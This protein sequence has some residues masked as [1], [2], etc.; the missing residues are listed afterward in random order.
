[1]YVIRPVRVEDLESIV[2]L[3]AGAGGGLTTMPSDHGVLLGRIENSVA[4]FAAKVDEAG[5]EY[6]LFVLEDS[7]TGQVIGTSAV[8]ATV[9]QTVPFYNYKVLKVVQV[10][11]DPPIKVATEM[12]SLAND[13]TGASEMA[14][15]YMDPHRRVGGLGRLLSKSRFMYMA[16]H[17][18][19]FSDLVIAELRG[20]VDENGRSPFWDA[21]G[22]K[23]FNMEF[24]D[25]DRINGLGNNQF[26]G[27]V[28]PKFPIYT[29]L[30]P[31]DARRVIGK[32]HE[33]S[34]IA[35]RFMEEEGFRYR[36]AVDIFDAG[37]IVEAHRSN[38]TSVRDTLLGTLDDTPDK[39]DGVVHMVANPDPANFKVINCPMT[40]KNEDGL[41]LSVAAEH[42]RLLGLESGMPIAYRR[43]W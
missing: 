19:R 29:N 20:W 28:M 34:A 23:F 7:E 17:G 10:S 5:D 2:Q 40:V 3:A 1:M 35:L 30:L 41:R 6:Y 37:P 15:L 12:L 22:R 8:F 14:T 9:G 21:V 11:Q 4:S 13:Y 43:E 33:Q 27:D 26:I 42:A 25:A 16:L 18:T 32:P 24:V 38:I 39:V 31:E 36:G